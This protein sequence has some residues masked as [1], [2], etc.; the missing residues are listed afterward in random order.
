MPRE[1]STDV[2]NFVARR[3]EDVDAALDEITEP[4]RDIFADFDRIGRPL[5]DA[6]IEETNERERFVKALRR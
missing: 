4:A 3:V 1:I 6:M 2:L 5:I